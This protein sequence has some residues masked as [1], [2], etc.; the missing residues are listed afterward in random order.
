MERVNRDLAID[1]WNEARPLPW[2]AMDGRVHFLRIAKN[3]S[4]FN[5]RNGQTMPDD[6]GNCCRVTGQATSKPWPLVCL[7]RKGKG[8]IRLQH[9]RL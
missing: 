4:E 7:V 8:L 1:H 3:A 2:Q 6:T 9:L 5:A